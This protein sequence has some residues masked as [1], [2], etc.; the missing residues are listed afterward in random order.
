[1]AFEV[2]TI[3][4]SLQFMSHEDL[5]LLIKEVV[6]ERSYRFQERRKEALNKIIKDLENLD[7]LCGDETIHIKNGAYSYLGLA[8]ILEKRRDSL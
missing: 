5:D 1:M 6:T 8:Q 2:D 3:I 4:D 7:E